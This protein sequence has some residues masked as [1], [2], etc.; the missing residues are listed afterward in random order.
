MGKT[1]IEKLSLLFEQCAGQ[2]LLTVLIA[3]CLSKA[4]QKKFS[5]ERSKA[6]VL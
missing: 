1:R 5:D 2:R 3:W 4:P 6:V